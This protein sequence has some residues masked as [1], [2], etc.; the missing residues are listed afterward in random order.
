MVA[1]FPLLP[2]LLSVT[3]LARLILLFR[4][5]L[6]V[7]LIGRAAPALRATVGRPGNPYIAGL[8][9]FV[10]IAG[11]G[12]LA[13][14][15]PGTADFWGA[16]WWALVT[17]TTV[18]S[19]DIAPASVPGRVI[20]VALVICGVSLVATVSARIAAYFV[21]TDADKRLDRNEECL[22]RLEQALNSER[23]NRERLGYASSCSLR[24]V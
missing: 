21:G 4:V 22:E 16:K 9:L 7:A 12:V 10:V 20:G 5:I 15:E 24:L 6:V 1:S 14:V 8:A 13:I 23:R 17:I 2:A 11:A 3:R 19:G 18:G